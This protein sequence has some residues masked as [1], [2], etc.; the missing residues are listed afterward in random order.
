[1]DSLLTP[2]LEALQIA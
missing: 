1:M 2:Y